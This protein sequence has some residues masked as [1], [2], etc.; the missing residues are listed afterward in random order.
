M[1]HLTGP[2]IF[3]ALL[4]VWQIFVSYKALDTRSYINGGRKFLEHARLLFRTSEQPKQ[5]QHI[6]EVRKELVEYRDDCTKRFLILQASQFFT[7][8][9]LLSAT[10]QINMWTL[11]WVAAMA[12]AHSIIAFKEI[13]LDR[14]VVDEVCTDVDEELKKLGHMTAFEDLLNENDPDTRVD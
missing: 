13:N 8:S 12:I 14:M 10:F 1:I 7:F 11:N 4:W 9:L 2:M 3:V 5:V 6:F